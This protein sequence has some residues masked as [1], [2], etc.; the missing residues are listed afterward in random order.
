MVAAGTSVGA[1]FG[2]NIVVTC[3]CCII[4]SYLRIAKFSRKFCSPKRFSNSITHKPK[5]LPN[6][7]SECYVT[8]S[9]NR[10]SEHVSLSQLF[11]WIWPMITVSDDDIIS[12]AGLDAA[13][14]MH[15]LS[16]GNH[17]H[18]LPAPRSVGRNHGCPKRT[19]HISPVFVLVTV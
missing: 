1:A 12:V 17:S 19:T 15:I 8:E 5:R 13:V 10:L 11:G 2:V 6:T 18:P 14:Y 16:L 4:F 9:M 3:I 7:V